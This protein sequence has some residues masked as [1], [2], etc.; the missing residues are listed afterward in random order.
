VTATP[1]YLA[2]TG[3]IGGAKLS[4]GLSRILGAGELVFVVN[5]ADDFKHLGLPISPDVDTLVYTLAGLNNPDTGWGRDGESWQFMQALEALGG[6]TWFRL[7]DKDL[8]MHVERRRRLQA[9][10]TLTET[11]RALSQ[12]LG[13]EHR[14]LPMSDD[15]VHT[16][17]RTATGLMDFQ[18]YFV[19][20]QC[21]PEVLGFKFSGAEQARLSAELSACL[22]SPALM[23]IILCPSN[24]FVSVDPILA[25]PGLRAQLAGCHAP[26]IAV[27]PVVGGQ[28]IKGPTV[29]M[30]QELGFPNTAAWVAE[31]YRDFL[32]GFVLDRADRDRSGDVTKLGLETRVTD[33][34]MLSLQDRIELAQTCLAFLRDLNPRAS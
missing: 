19:R 26:V 12:S 34:V 20:E 13:I 33:T 5:T 31:H 2:I 4:L 30:M 1:F 9:G 23:G 27:S 6:E 25:I 16:R 22:A 14:I 18:H 24:P 11:T 7:G 8:A 21:A 10:Q 17:V 32:D 15:P 3:G 28:A 29:K